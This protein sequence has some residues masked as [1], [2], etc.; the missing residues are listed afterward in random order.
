MDLARGHA[1]IVLLPSWRAGVWLALL[2]WLTPVSAAMGLATALAARGAAQAAGAADDERTVAVFNGLLVGWFISSAWQPSLAAVGLTVFCGALAGWLSVAL[3]RATASLLHLPVLSLPFVLIAGSLGAASSS[4]AALLARY[5][6]PPSAWL[7]APFDSVLGAFGGLFMHSDPRQGL[8]VAA[9]IGVTSRYTL[10]MATAACAVA[11]AGLAGLGLVPPDLESMPW[12]ANALL[13]ALMV[14]ATVA[15]PSR[16]TAALAMFAALAAAW[17]T[18]ACSRLGEPLHLEPYSLPFV[19]SAWTVLYAATRHPRLAGYFNLSRP[20]LPERSHERAQIARSRVG[21]P[22]SVPLLPPYAGSWTVSQGFDGPHTHRGAWRHA[23]DFIV[24]YEG[25]SFS[26]S[27]QRLEDFYSYGQPVLSPAWGQV[28]QVVDGIP[29]NP[30][31]TVNAAAN[32]GNL[33]VIRLHGGMCVLLAHLQPGSL[34]VATGAWVSPGML[35]ARCGNSGRSPQ[36]HIHMHVQ[37]GEAPGA[38]TRPFHLANV[39][40]TAPGG[41]DPTP[42]PAQ[43]RLALVPETGCQLGSADVGPVR[44]LHLLAGRGL[45][46]EVTVSGCEGRHGRPPASHWSLRCEIDAQGRFVLVSS[47]GARCAVESTAAVF[48]CYDRDTTP[49]PL[50]DLWLLACGYTPASWLVSDWDERCTPARLMPGRVAR[51]LGTVAWPWAATVQSRHQ[52]RWDEAAQ[53]WEQIAGHRQRISGLQVH[54][55]ACLT[56]ASGCLLLQ[57]EAGGVRRTFIATAVF[58]TADLGVPGWQADLAPLAMPQ[59][60]GSAGQAAQQV[61]SALVR[62]R[63]IRPAV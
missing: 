36:P 50:F 56:A 4:L 22:G 47:A 39:L 53:C 63:A 49:D 27:G 31:G 54:T 51:L 34:A 46:Y 58:Q 29:D 13:A 21:A 8:L 42:R 48:S 38:P 52:R 33:I 23:L 59:W 28:C 61:G 18:L 3:G 25:R 35:L 32:W 7:G 40:T 41:M 62:P 12:A 17:L 26:A 20:D 5:D 16:V 37:L 24:I 9:V 2:T 60:A 10:A 55:R 19:L 45:R 6:P 15:V 44:P 30:P 14:G 43:Y 57:A 1:W 11:Y